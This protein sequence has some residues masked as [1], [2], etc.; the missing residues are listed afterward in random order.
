MDG[1]QFKHAMAELGFTKIS[2]EAVAEPYRDALLEKAWQ[3]L[4]EHPDQNPIFPF[5]KGQEIV[6]KAGK[7][8]PLR[9]G[10]YV[11]Q[12]IELFRNLSDKV[13]GVL[14][15]DPFDPL[16]HMRQVADIDPSYVPLVMD[17]LEVFAKQ[18]Y[19]CTNLLSLNARNTIT[20]LKALDPAYVPLV[21][22][23]VKQTGRIDV[24]T[25]NSL[26]VHAEYFLQIGGPDYFQK[27]VDAC[28]RVATANPPAAFTLNIT[29]RYMFDVDKG[30]NLPLICKTILALTDKDPEVGTDF[31]QWSPITLA[32]CL[33]KK[34][35]PTQKDLLLE[36]LH[37]TKSAKAMEGLVD[38][39]DPAYIEKIRRFY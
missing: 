3:V 13:D 17:A 8:I 2:W 39:K 14:L 15:L 24:P 30:A 31:A 6:M 23:T 38:R 7:M 12:S 4:E 27:V 10:A 32:L 5:T 26:S 35:N 33:K 28:Q 21:Y 19:E 11:A 29:C 22:E 1:A 36:Y 34:P 20:G 25:A 9:D 18:D 16:P 37:D